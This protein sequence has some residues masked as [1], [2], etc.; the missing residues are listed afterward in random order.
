MGF[1]LEGVYIVYLDK[2]RDCV[3]NELGS[4][5]IRRQLA[6]HRADLWLSPKIQNGF[7]EFSVIRFVCERPHF[8]FAVVLSL[9]FVNH[10]P[11]KQ[12][13]Y[14][15]GSI[16]SLHGGREPQH[17]FGHN[18]EECVGKRLTGNMMDFVNYS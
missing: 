6:N 7:V 1:N 9:G 4:S 15:C 2:I 5:V 18:F 3:N 11:Q 13:E 14:L 17:V 8:H 12:L 16:L 10:I